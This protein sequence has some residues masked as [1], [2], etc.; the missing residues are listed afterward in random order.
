V[1][2]PLGADG[3]GVVVAIDHG[4][5]CW[6]VPGLEDRRALIAAVVAAGTDAL[7]ASYGTIRELR[8]AFGGAAAIL[9]LDL[10]PVSV[11]AYR[12]VEFSV[13]WTV[14]DARRLAAAAVLTLVQLGTPWELETL[15]AAARVAVAADAEGLPYVCEILPY[16]GGRYPDPFA[17]EAIAG[18]AR[19]A[20]ELGA[21]LVK[22]SMP[23]PPEAVADVAAACGLPVLIAGGDVRDRDGLLDATARAV[24]AGAAGV[25]YGRNVW[26]GGD[27]AGTVA[28]LREIVHGGR[29]ARRSDTS[30]HVRDR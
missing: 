3:R 20:A 2:A 27:P 30:R 5:Y 10:A 11:G 8:D 1:T 14:A 28:R 21:H 23:E 22:T 25:A 4:L 18:A 16:A 12:D 29:G 26:S 24:A 15:R 19:T 9:K 6:P 7:I 13:A 17:P